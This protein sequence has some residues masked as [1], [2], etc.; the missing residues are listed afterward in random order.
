VRKLLDAYGLTERVGATNV[1]PNAR[2]AIAAY[3][4]GAGSEAGAGDG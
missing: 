1:Y 3:E 2:A 4:R